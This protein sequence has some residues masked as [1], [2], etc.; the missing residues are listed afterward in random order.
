MSTTG[1]R[2]AGPACVRNVSVLRGGG[3]FCHVI[4][5]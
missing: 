3:D 2:T 1:F 5:F 4:N